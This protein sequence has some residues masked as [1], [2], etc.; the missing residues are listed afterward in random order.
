MRRGKLGGFTLIELL[1]VIAIIAVL[2]ALLLPAVQQAREA[3]RRS[4]CKN[5][6]KQMGLALHNYHDT[7][8]VLPPGA[9]HCLASGNSGHNFYADIL[10]YIDQAN[11]YNN[12]NWG[13]PGYTCSAPPAA[14]MVAI[15]TI[16]TPYICPSSTTR[17]IW[18]YS[19]CPAAFVGAVAQYVGISGSTNAASLNGRTYAA[20]GG[21]FH[22]NSKRSVRDFTDG[23]S[24]VMVVGE[25][26]GL[27]K[28]AG[29]GKQSEACAA[30]RVNTTIWYGFYDNAPPAGTASNSGYAWNS[31]K[32]VAYAPNLYW[33]NLD[34]CSP[35]SSVNAVYNQQSLKSE[36]VGGVHI[37]LGDG[38][39]RF[40]S[41]N[42]SLTTLFN[43][44]DIA[45]GNV[46]GEF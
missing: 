3:A 28:G 22:K 32:T 16:I 8:Q 24:N 36:H 31:Y 26:S 13:V 34:S 27:A 46:V 11:V 37:L 2:I 39:V 23:T 10:P 42:I 14:H 45:D 40:L 6:L 44:A 15:N 7:F 33:N 25:Y 43:L 29:N 30:N 19:A 5:N 20:T 18:S 1:V 4:Q 35:T 38:A 17:A 21:T 12:L 41:E 9:T